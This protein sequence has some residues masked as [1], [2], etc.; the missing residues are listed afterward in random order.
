MTS[1][2]SA[3]LDLGQSPA[4]ART[5][6]PSTIAAAVLPSHSERAPARA[7]NAPASTD[8]RVAPP[9]SDFSAAEQEV[10]VEPQIEAKRGEG[11]TVDERR[12]TRGEEALVLV[13]KALVEQA[14]DDEADDGVAEEL[15]ALVVPRD[16]AG[17]LVEVGAVDECLAD[18]RPGLSGRCRD[19]HPDRPAAERPWAVRLLLVLLDELD[20]VGDLLDAS[21]HPRPRSPC[22]TPPRGS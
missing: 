6:A 7:S 12:A 9:A 10:S 5:G 15:E 4:A 18:Q 17:I 8:G 14:A 11:V 19:A 2:T 3:G 20:G 22:R 16:G 1:P 21:R 13:G